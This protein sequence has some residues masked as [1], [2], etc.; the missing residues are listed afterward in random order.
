MTKEREGIDGFRSKAKRWRN[1]ELAFYILHYALGVVALALSTFWATKPQLPPAP[2]LAS[3]WL[4]AF[5]TGLLTF[6]SAKAN[7]ERYRDAREIL[8]IE[9]GRYDVDNS[10][11]YNHVAAA[12]TLGHEIIRGRITPGDLQKKNAKA[13]KDR[14]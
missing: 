2:D 14:G 12:F 11:T 5:L 1:A 6:L 3:R 4:I 13:Q 10:Y 8:E 9:I 7:A